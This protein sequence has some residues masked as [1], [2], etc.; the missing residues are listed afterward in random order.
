LSIAGRTAPDIDGHIEN[1]AGNAAHQLVLGC[2]GRLEMQAPDHPDITAQRLI[3][4]HE[5]DVGDMLGEP[6]AAKYL[7]KIPATVGMP[8]RRDF[9]NIG[10]S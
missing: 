9:D 7:G 5:G 3:F 1:G 2:G 10:N 4:L 6:V 8:N